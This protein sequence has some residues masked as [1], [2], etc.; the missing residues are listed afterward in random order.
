MRKLSFLIILLLMCP[1]ISKAKE[2]MPSSG[3]AL[4]ASLD[5]DSAAVGSVVTLN[6]KYSLPKG[7]GFSAHPEIK[8]LEDLT[9]VNR[10]IGPDR[11]RVSLLVDRLGSW[12]TG[13]ISLT[14]VDKDG[15]SRNLTTEPVSLTVLS[16]LGEKPEEVTLRPIRG[17]MPTEPTWLKVLPWAAGI[18]IFLLIVSVM[19]WFYKRN[20]SLKSSM[21]AAD[22]PHIRAQKE[23]EN[24]EAAGLFEK[25]EVKAYYFRFSEILRNYLESLRGFPAAEFTTEEIAS[26]IAKETDRS[27]VPLLRQAD[28]LKFA[29]TVP[30]N[31]R[32]EEI[33]SAALSYIRE[34]ST[35]EDNGHETYSSGETVQ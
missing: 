33:V 32:K 16:N 12:K 8:G 11:I 13:P 15:K 2:P 1:G 6:L 24:L 27:L 7:S 3:P 25:G 34:T 19:L 35:A 4:T 9:E 14:Y 29:D 10:E 17:I 26:F 22:P 5:E 23:L 18:V 28:R 20:R 31:A 30:T 21:A